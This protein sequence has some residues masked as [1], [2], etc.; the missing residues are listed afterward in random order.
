MLQ[1][2]EQVPT[3]NDQSWMDQLLQKYKELLGVYEDAPKAD[4]GSQGGQRFSR[5]VMQLKKQM[6]TPLKKQME[7]VKQQ[8]EHLS[9]KAKR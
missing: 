2:L 4:N 5:D 6:E 8:K 1:G 7:Q 3:P 9:G